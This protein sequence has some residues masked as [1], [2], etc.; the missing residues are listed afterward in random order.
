MQIPV[1]LNLY[2]D[3]GTM[4]LRFFCSTHTHTHTHTQSGCSL[5]QSPEKTNDPTSGRDLI[6]VNNEKIVV[7]KK[8]LL[9]SV[10]L[11]TIF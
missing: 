1:Y 4:L 9:E 8:S 6:I 7:R 11:T 5:V 2:H 3:I 10:F